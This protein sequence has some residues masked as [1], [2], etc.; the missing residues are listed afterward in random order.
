LIWV[1]LD[2]RAGTASQ[3]LGVAEALGRP[4]VEKTIRYGLWGR[5]PNLLRGATLIGLAAEAKAALMPPWPD[6]V[7]SAG[8]R[9]AP[10]A[11]RIKRH[12]G[13]RVVLV[14]VM[15][16]DTGWQDF[17]LIALPSHDAVPAAGDGAN[18]M[19][20]AGAPH[21]LTQ[22]RLA[23]A[24]PAWE[25]RLRDL[26]R[27]RI[28]LAVGGA[29]RRRAFPASLA[30]DLGANVARM[31]K[32]AGGSVL[33]I[34]SRRTGREAEAALV[35]AVDA[36]RLTSLWG[37]GGDNPYLAFLGAA[38]AIVVTGDS[39]SMCSEACAVGPP[40]FIYAPPGLVI[41]KHLR[42]H[43]ALYATGCARPFDGRYA[44]WTHP[45]L[46]SA[47]AVAAAIERLI[48]TVGAA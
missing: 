5:A 34:T 3:A 1:L 26:A 13:K 19:R 41:A 6:V 40:V 28:T 48:T 39:V 46:N 11:R 38:D 31:A 23:A 29:T 2:D 12:A 42:M 21:R 30:G 9:A 8:R 16:P 47:T 22:A 7:I 25:E 27:P 18:V 37:Q 44:H 14:Q 43:E 17:D 4:Y 35:A 15:S 24:T 33:L 45:P 10:V 36:P 32:D 20:T